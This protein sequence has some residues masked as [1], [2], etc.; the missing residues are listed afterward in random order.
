LADQ[1]QFTPDRVGNDSST[2]ERIRGLKAPS[3]KIL[4][5]LAYKRPEIPRPSR[6]SSTLVVTL[7]RCASLLLSASG[8]VL[9]AQ[10]SLR[11]TITLSVSCNRPFSQISFIS[12]HV[13]GGG[14]AGLVV[15]GRL[16]EDPNISVLVLEA[17]SRCVSLATTSHPAHEPLK[18]GSTSKH[19]S[20]VT[21]V[22]L[23]SHV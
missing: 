9:P 16:S 4:W 6:P 19:H 7:A 8:L 17:G 14:T 23:T 2:D 15:A 20:V 1:R 12:R 10:H 11:P 13:V 21:D 22:K 5:S 3:P 18:A